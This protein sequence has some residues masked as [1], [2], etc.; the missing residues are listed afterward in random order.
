MPVTR[1]ERL[2]DT[3]PEVLRPCAITAAL[4]PVKCLV[5]DLDNTLWRGTLLE[6]GAVA[7]REEA[8]R[9]IRLL[10]N[11]GI[12]QSIASKNDHHAAMSKLRELGIADYFLYPQI[13]W[14]SKVAAV[15]NISRSL[16]IGLDSIAF[17][18]DQV[19]ERAEVAFSL[20]QVRC[21]DASAAGALAERDEFRPRWV[22][23]ES[24]KRR[25]M[26]RA[27]MERK[28]VEREF[29]GPKESFLASLDMVFTIKSA[30][31]DDLKR[32]E[33]LTVR[34]NQLNTTGYTYSYDDLDGFRRSDDH[35]LY[36]TSLSDRFGDYGKIGLALVERGA[37][38]WTIKLL[39]MS[40]R[41][42][43]RGV[44]MILIGH[45]ME[46][47]GAA[48]VGLQVEFVPNG[49]N[50]MMLITYTFAGFRQIARRGDTL[51][52]AGDIDKRQP[53]PDY[54]TVHHRS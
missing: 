22:T 15:E 47:A 35:D 34:T 18:D 48:G 17:I 20:P 44:G 21:Y 10:D 7:V 6:P 24:K 32:A 1:I 5:W 16:N 14:S 45:I 49:R 30:S 23:D 28:Q 51:I 8:L 2:P 43:N 40:C 29:V 31:E 19:A 50:R 37:S 42:M 25:H 41:V 53:A 54:V 4:G 38:V 13:S 33:E 46:R 3:S 39:L 11:R 52:L 36:I 9:T 27:D 26:Y 12:L